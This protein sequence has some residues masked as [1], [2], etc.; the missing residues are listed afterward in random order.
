MRR[1]SILSIMLCLLSLHVHAAPG[2]SLRKS[3][4]NARPSTAVEDYGVQD[5]NY[6]ML[7]ATD[8]RP[9]DSTTTYMID[10]IDNQTSALTLHRTGGTSVWFAHEIRL[11]P[12]VILQ[13]IRAYVSDT[14]AAQDVILDLCSTSRHTDT[15][16]TPSYGCT[17]ATTMGT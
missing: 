2:Q 9:L 7:S 16:V 15:G 14:N 6:T 12:G 4:E 3:L 10:E 17:S 5:S 1:V 11:P 8:F 13:S